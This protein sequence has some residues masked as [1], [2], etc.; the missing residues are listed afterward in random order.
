MSRPYGF[1]LVAVLFFSSLAP[2]AFAL[3]TASGITYAVPSTSLSGY[4]K[5]WKSS[6]EPDYYTYC[7]AWYWDDIYHTLTCTAYIIEKYL[8]SVV[9][10]LYT[11][12]SS[13]YRTGY[14]R[15]LRTANSAY[16]FSLIGPK[17]VWQAQ[18]RHYLEIEYY[19]VECYA[20][21]CGPAV[22]F[23][24]SVGDLGT[25]DANHGIISLEVTYH[26]TVT[27]ISNTVVDSSILTGIYG[28]NTILQTNNGGGD[29]ACPMSFVRSGPVYSFSQGDGDI[30]TYA[31]KEEVYNLPGRI[32]V[33]HA[34][35]YCGAAAPPGTFYGCTPIGYPTTIVVRRPADREGILWAHEYGHEEWLLDGNTSGWVMYEHEGAGN[36]RVTQSECDAMRN[37][38]N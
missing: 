37:P 16:A 17:G 8:V 25:T 6:T 21:Y 11:P 1:I 33:V 38:A 5:T 19:Y 20:Y 24:Q 29:V 3:N 30:D 9:G 28:A 31:E 35:N 36:T 12:A 2:C 7:V 13:L 4:S 23:G 14:V 10:N 22:Y 27:N 15:D 26:T 18:G 32:H 34:L